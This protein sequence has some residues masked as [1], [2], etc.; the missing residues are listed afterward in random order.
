[1]KVIRK[2]LKFIYERGFCL[3]RTQ[4]GTL[5]DLNEWGDRAVDDATAEIEKIVLRW[6]GSDKEI[7]PNDDSFDDGFDSGYNYRGADIK[8]KIE[9]SYE[10][11]R[12]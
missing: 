3:A 7:K 5:H 2:C 11:N 8:K 6:V 4:D 10:A 1:M 12:R 9:D